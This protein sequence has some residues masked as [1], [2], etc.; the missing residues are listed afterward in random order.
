MPSSTLFSGTFSPTSSTRPLAKGS[1]CNAD[2]KRSRREISWAAA[3]S[4]VTAI[5]SPSSS[6]KRLICA[7]YSGLRTRAMVCLAPSFFPM[8]QHS[9]F[10]S[11]AEVAAMSKSASGTPASF[12]SA[13]LHPLPSTQMISIVLPAFSNAVALLSMMM[14]S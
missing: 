6:F 11:S 1:I 8:R 2:G 4:G 12:C 3:D 13:A 5:L 10:T 14:I 9:I 7:K